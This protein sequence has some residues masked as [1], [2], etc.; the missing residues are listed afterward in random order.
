MVHEDSQI[1]SLKPTE[2]EKYCLKMQESD[3]Y[4]FR[5]ASLLIKNRILSQGRIDRVLLNEIEKNG[6]DGFHRY[7][8]NKEQALKSES[9]ASSLSRGSLLTKLRFIKVLD[10]HY[11]FVDNDS[12]S[13]ALL[14]KRLMHEIPS[15]DEIYQA[16]VLDVKKRNGR[17]VIFISMEKEPINFPHPP[18]INIDSLIDVSFS[19]SK[20]GQWHLIKNSYC[21]LLTMEIVSRPRLL[22]YRKKQQAKILKQ[23][24]F[25]TYKVAL[26]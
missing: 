15:S 13:Y 21:K 25:F 16:F 20:D 1:E 2:I 7:I 10:N 14:D 26:V 18:L 9:I 12:Q 19:Q 22:D 11:L 4:A 24:D 6:F 5:T 3:S 23:V 8:I 17:R